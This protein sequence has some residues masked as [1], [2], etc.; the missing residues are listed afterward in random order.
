[1]TLTAERGSGL[2]HTLA[3]IF[4][5]ISL[6]FVWRSFYAMRIHS[7]AA[8]AATAKAQVRRAS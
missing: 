1:M 7:G 5:A 8:P 6:V 2:S 3:A 4:F